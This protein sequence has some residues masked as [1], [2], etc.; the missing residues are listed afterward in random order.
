MSFNINLRLNNL[1]RQI[2]QLILEAGLQNPLDQDIQGNNYNING[3]NEVNC[4]V[5]NTANTSGVTV[6]ASGITC[7]EISCDNITCAG[8]VS[9]NVLSYNTLSPPISGVAEPL[10]KVLQNGNDASNNSITNL[11]GLQM[12]GNLNLNYNQITAWNDGTIGGSLS[13]ANGD[14]N[15]NDT[16]CELRFYNNA[17]TNFFMGKGDIAGQTENFNNFRLYDSNN[18]EYMQIYPVPTQQ[19]IF[20]ADKLLSRQDSSNPANA[21]GYILD[22]IKTPPMYKQIF[23]NVNQSISLNVNSEEPSWIFGTNIYTGDQVF[24]Y[25]VTYAEILFS[26]LQI[27]FQSEDPF[28]APNNCQLY[29]GPTP[30][31]TYDPSKGNR[32][33]F[34]VVDN[35]GD[36]PNFTFTSSIPI[37]LYYQNGDLGSGNQFDNLYLNIQI[38]DQQVYNISFQNTNFVVSSYICGKNSDPLAWN[39]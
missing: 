24:N 21:T 15:G 11:G 30:N 18:F 39:T 5:L 26:Y 28:L 36:Q 34:S 16:R 17:E 1:Q 4:M 27:N 8:D 7:T 25:G 13:I 6:N 31:Y 10:G 9:C 14:H 35:T 23:S 29:L 19:I 20:S 37:I 12:T 3:I 38:Q 32:I 33:V 2:N 22:S